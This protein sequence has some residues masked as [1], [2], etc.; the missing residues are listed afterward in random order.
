MVDDRCGYAID[1]AGKTAAEVSKEMGRALVELAVEPTRLLFA[2]SAKR[3][4]DE[5]SWPEKVERIYG[6]AS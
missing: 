2:E 6:L 3:R 1:P 5:F 4:C